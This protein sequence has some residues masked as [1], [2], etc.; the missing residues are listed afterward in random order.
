MKLYDALEM[1]FEFVCFLV[2]VFGLSLE[3]HITLFLSSSLSGRGFGS[4]GHMHS[5]LLRRCS[6]T[7]PIHTSPAW[8]TEPPWA[9]WQREEAHVPGSRLL[10][11]W[12]GAGCR[13]EGLWALIAQARSAAR[14]TPLPR[15][16][17]QKPAGGRDSR[18]ARASGRLLSGVRKRVS[19]QDCR[20]CEAHAACGVPPREAWFP[21]KL[22]EKHEATGS[23]PEVRSQEMQ[24]SLYS[25]SF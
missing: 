17:L 13:G 12:K 5:L 25:G 11:F 21:P 24:A 3:K 14:G 20:V 2:Y 19:S 6:G 9:S 8:H 1:I 18:L 4:S 7:D 15:E 22:Y 10:P 23:W 16:M